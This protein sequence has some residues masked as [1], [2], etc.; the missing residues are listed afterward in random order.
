MH[1]DYTYTRPNK[2]QG[3]RYIPVIHSLWQQRN[4]AICYKS[5]S[6]QQQMWMPMTTSRIA[7]PRVYVRVTGNSIC[8]WLRCMMYFLG[9]AINRFSTFLGGKISLRRKKGQ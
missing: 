5:M 6:R 7:A 9:A 2:G 4:T 1:M 8:I 3:Y